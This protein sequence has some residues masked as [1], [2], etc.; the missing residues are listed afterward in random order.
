MRCVF[1]VF[2]FSSAYQK[3]RENVNDLTVMVRC[4]FTIP[5]RCATSFTR[6]RK[7]QDHWLACSGYSS[8]N[9][10]HLYVYIDVGA[11]MCAKINNP[12]GTRA[13]TVHAKWSLLERCQH[14]M[15][16]WR[17][18]MKRDRW[19]SGRKQICDADYESMKNTY[20]TSGVSSTTCFIDSLWN[21][22][23][24]QWPLE[25]I[26][27]LDTFQTWKSLFIWTINDSRR[28]GWD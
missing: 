15:L 23:K 11:C 28:M 27:H 10:L 22:M 20:T 4:R 3:K 13:R 19:A 8:T 14:W 21:L 1:L 7:L 24:N 2:L 17:I 18:T 6:K 5:K 26:F 16:G 12:R 9:M 25:Y